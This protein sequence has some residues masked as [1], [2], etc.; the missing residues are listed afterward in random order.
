[1][2]ELPNKRGSGR[3]IEWGRGTSALLLVRPPARPFSHLADGGQH[4]GPVGP[5]G[6]GAPLEGAPARLDGGAADGR[7]VAKRPGR[8]LQGEAVLAD[9]G[10][11]HP[12][13]GPPRLGGLQF[14]HQVR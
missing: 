1:M 11:N 4:H 6:G 10:Q 9:R 8:V 2:R 12:W 14:C 13:V 7:V 3:P 5:H